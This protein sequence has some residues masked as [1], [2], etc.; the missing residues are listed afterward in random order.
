M[1]I[2]SKVYKGIEYVL[3]SELPRE[4]QE[5]LNASLNKSLLIKI[6]INGKITSDCLQYRDYK[7]WYE[8]I[9]KVQTPVA[10]NTLAKNIKSKILKALPLEQH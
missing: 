3:L 4:Q 9:F 8:S 2:K 1:M 6:L 5:I 10:D 7:L